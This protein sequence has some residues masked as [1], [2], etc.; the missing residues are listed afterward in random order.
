M[1]IRLY[2]N[3]S[4]QTHGVNGR[5]QSRTHKNNASR[6]I[7]ED[8]GAL[9]KY[10]MFDNHAPQR[11]AADS[12]LMQYVLMYHHNRLNVMEKTYVELHRAPITHNRM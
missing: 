10:N 6:L 8:G 11:P 9:S 3:I 2:T 4:F 5:D 7:T 12:A 1:Y